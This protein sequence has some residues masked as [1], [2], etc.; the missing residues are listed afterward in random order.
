MVVI[1]SSFTSMLAAI[2]SFTMRFVCVIE[3]DSFRINRQHWKIVREQF[4]NTRDETSFIVS[5]LVIKVNTWIQI[6]LHWTKQCRFGGFFLFTRPNEWMVFFP[7]RRHKQNG[8]VSRH[9]PCRFY[10]SMM[11][12]RNISE[13]IIGITQYK[14][15]QR[16]YRH[17]MLIIIQ[18][19]EKSTHS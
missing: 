5:F 4:F 9:Y 7:A 16:G 6:G 14:W 2:Q 10:E 18:F 13:L 11:N 1:I 8:P 19:A 15:A 3:F 17:E 12:L